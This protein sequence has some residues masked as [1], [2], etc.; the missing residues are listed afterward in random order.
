MKKNVRFLCLLS[1]LFGFNVPVFAHNIQIGSTLPPVQITEYGELHNQ[2]DL[3]NYHPWSSDSLIGKVRIIQAIAGR[4]QARELNQA[5][6]DAIIAANLSAD[7]YQTTTIVNQ[8][9]AIFATG[10]FVKSSL[11][12]SKREFPWSSMVLDKHGE[13]AQSWELMA[14][15][16]AIIVLD[17]SATVHFVQEGSLSPD[18]IQQ[19]MELIQTLI[20]SPQ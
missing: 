9:D 12:S 11:E 16:S 7:H 5:L 13:V 1:V 10:G 20:N 17:Q 6:I 4:T 8:N 2:D 15:S 14:K 3:L 19:V 18:H